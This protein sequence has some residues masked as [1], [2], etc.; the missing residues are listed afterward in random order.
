MNNGVIGD[1]RRYSV[2]S[3]IALCTVTETLH[4]LHSAEFTNI[5]SSSE[6]SVKYSEPSGW[7]ARGGSKA[8]GP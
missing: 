6:P 2:V 4:N 5:F 8:R 7:I 3:T 1:R